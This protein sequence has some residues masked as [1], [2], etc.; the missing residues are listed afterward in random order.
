[1][2]VKAGL[3]LSFWDEAIN[4][5]CYTQNRSII[6]KCYGMAAYELLK[7]RKFDISYFHI[8]WYVWYIQNKRDHRSNLKQKIT[9]VSFWDIQVNMRPSGSLVFQDKSSGNRF[10]LRLMMTLSF[11]IELIILQIFLTRLFSVHPT[12]FLSQLS[13]KIDLVHNL[14]Y[15]VKDP[16][17]VDVEVQPIMFKIQT[18]M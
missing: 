17:D 10:M 4:I 2:V 15:D 12:L 1:M 11:K 5:A 18:P 6:V 8:F 9:N 16:T 13:Q 7:R 14:L 3:P